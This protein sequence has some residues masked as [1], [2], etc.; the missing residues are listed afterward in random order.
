MTAKINVKPVKKR[1]TRRNSKACKSI[2]PVPKKR[3]GWGKEKE[4]E[5]REREIEGGRGKEEIKEKKRSGR[6]GE[7]V[8]WQEEGI[9]TVE[10]G[11]AHFVRGGGRLKFQFVFRAN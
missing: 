1:R 2:Y 5:E 4:G 3:G 8:G 11:R 6:R 9:V 10:E 7:K